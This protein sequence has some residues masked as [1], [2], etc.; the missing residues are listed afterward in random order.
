MAYKADKWLDFNINA[1]CQT[2]N[3][4]LKINGRKVLEDAKFAEST[5]IV[6]ALSFRT[7][8]FRGKAP[9]RA[10]R[11]IPETEEPSPKVAYRIDDVVT[12]N[13]KCAE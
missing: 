6:Y 4:T 1:D 13:P 11:D 10:G 3:Y 7:G 9:G 8:A 2:G 12:T 5:P